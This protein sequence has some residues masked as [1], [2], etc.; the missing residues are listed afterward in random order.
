MMNG[1]H[2]SAAGG[3]FAEPAE[4]LKKEGRRKKEERA[5][6]SRAVSR[7]KK[8]RLERRPFQSFAGLAGAGT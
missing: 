6:G 1:R 8:G 5:W 2:A 4:G 7:Y 3:G